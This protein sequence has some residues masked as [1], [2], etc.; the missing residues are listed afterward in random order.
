MKFEELLQNKYVLYVTLG[1]AVTN[2]LGYAALKNSDALIMFFITGLLT[3]Y[4]SKNMIVI[5]LSAMLLTNFIVVGR[6]GM[7]REGF[8]MKKEEEGESEKGDRKKSAELGGGLAEVAGVK[9]KYEEEEGAEEPKAAL[10]PYAGLESRRHDD[11]QVETGK[12]R[13][14]LS[15]GKGPQVEKGTKELFTQDIQYSSLKPNNGAPKRT[16]VPRLD[17]SATLEQAYNDLEKLLSPDQMKGLS[18]DTQKLVQQQQ[19][20]GESIKQIAPL[21]NTAN[22]MMQTL[23]SAGAPIG[24]L[25]DK[26][27]GLLGTA[28]AS[29][30]PIDPENVDL[31]QISK[32]AQTLASQSKQMA[33]AQAT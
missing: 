24:K 26:V 14:N 21:L 4:F 7:Q 3:S 9:K 32:Q 27:G 25:L 2:V 8:E 15:N 13:L 5:M 22:S 33:A 30:Q 23:G 10:G 11:D 17:Q 20:L 29:G 6:K 19:Q 31:Q 12:L 18:A 16:D 1:L 28:K